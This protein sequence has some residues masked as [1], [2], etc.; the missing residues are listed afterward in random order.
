[1]TMEV[2]LK[3]IDGARR[4]TRGYMALCP[5]HAD[6]SPSMS[7]CEGDDGRILLHCFAGCTAEEICSALGVSVKDLFPGGRPPRRSHLPRPSPE[8][9]LD[10]RLQLHAL[11]LRLRA[12]SIIAAGTG[13]NVD[14]WSES[15]RDEAIQYIAF[16]TADN[17]RADVLDDVAFTL[18]TRKLAKEPS[19]ARRRRGAQTSHT[20]TIE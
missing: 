13:V 10:F 11:D 2:F 4:S 1:M 19:H 6:G 16:A 12:E 3:M 20:K 18:R 15:D 14:E 5:A 17:E 7:A 8:H 9:A